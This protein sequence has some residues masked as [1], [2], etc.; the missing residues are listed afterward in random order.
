MTGTDEHGEKIALAAEKRGMSP[1][2]HCDSIAEEYRDLWRQVRCSRQ[3]IRL[4][5]WM[6]LSLA[7]EKA[8][9]VLRYLCPLCCFSGQ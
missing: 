3:G 1:Q 7:L 6:A 9:Q 4:N 5:A 8:H 2:A